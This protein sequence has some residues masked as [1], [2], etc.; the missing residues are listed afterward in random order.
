MKRVLLATDFSD[1]ADHAIEYALMLF[2]NEQV[3][4]CLLNSYGLLHNIPETLI[5][6]ED[7]LREQS[8]KGLAKTLDR[9]KKAH[10]E[11]KI[12]SLSLYGDAPTII[13]KV[14]NERKVDLVVLGN[15]GSTLDG[16][17]YGST[18]TQ[19]ARGMKQPMLIVPYTHSGES[20]HRIL[21]ATD[22]VQI[23]DLNVLDSM[24]E[25]ARKFTSEIVVMNVTSPSEH[26]KVEQ[27]IKRLD[28]NNHF[29]GISSKFE[30]V[31]N[32][33]IISGINEYANNYRADLLVVSPKRYPYFKNLFHKSITQNMV[34]HSEIPVMVI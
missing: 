29:D 19:L 4:Y 16:T 5:S 32:E 26:R 12:E 23:K 24:L 25:V 28:F 21:L 22:L 11:V 2:G 18:T 6:L 31:D 20:P 27:A 33:D 7:I 17:I 8:E 34:K 13:K 14:A 30:V 3:E 9:I 15:K 10:Q 1:N